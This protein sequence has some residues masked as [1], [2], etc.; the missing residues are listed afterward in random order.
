MPLVAI[1]FFFEEPG[2]L[3]FY[4]G[5]SVANLL[6]LANNQSLSCQ[7]KSSQVLVKFESLVLSIASFSDNACRHLC[8]DK[9][10]T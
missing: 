3:K 5:A 1:A 6:H 8:P 9:Y 2:L 7:P 10:E 4:F